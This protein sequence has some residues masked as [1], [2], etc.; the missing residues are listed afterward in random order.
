MVE[1][2][3]GFVAAMLVLNAL[4]VALV[5]VSA[6]VWGLRKLRSRPAA[7]GDR[8]PSGPIIEGGLGAI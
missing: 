1:V 5:A 6:A 8:R 4:F 3:A 2:C 7:G